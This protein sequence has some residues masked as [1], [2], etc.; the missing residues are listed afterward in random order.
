MNTTATNYVLATD[1]S[2]DLPYEF[3]EREG[4]ICV[5]LTLVFEGNE[6][7]YKNRDID[8]KTFY[9]KIRNGDIA[10]TSAVNPEEF[11]TAFEPILQK[12]QDILYLGLDSTISTTVGSAKIAAEE[13]SEI[14]PNRNILIVDTLCASAG[15]GLVIF[16][17]NELKKT[18]ATLSEAYN[19]A[20]ITCPKV[21]HRF[22]V[23]TLTYLKRGGRV[24][25]ASCIVGN[26][27]NIKPVLHV[28]DEGHLV[29][30]GKSHGRKKSLEALADAYGETAS[31]PSSGTVFISQ[32]DSIEDANYL[33]SLLN[34]RYGVNV[35]MIT[36]IGPVIGSHAGPGTI[37]LF[38]IAKER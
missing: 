29:S 17:L 16:E 21:S 18:G 19:Y 31:D 28:D 8:T 14:Y 35:D 10:K 1:S 25:S 37:A 9:D 38:F 36:D 4:I 32:A 30:I 11:K 5:D 22:T 23:E 33:S 7:R 3:M 6:E 27:L 2:A 12:G 26:V 34:G 24:S 15:I 20:L 13:L